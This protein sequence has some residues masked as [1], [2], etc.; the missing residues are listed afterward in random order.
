M[1]LTAS[2]SSNSVSIHDVEAPVTF[3]LAEQSQIIS[4]QN[5]G[6]R[7]GDWGEDP[8]NDV[9]QSLSAGARSLQ[10]GA[11]H[12]ADLIGG[13]IDTERKIIPSFEIKTTD[14]GARQPVG[15][16]PARTEAWIREAAQGRIGNQSVSAVDQAYAEDLRILLDQGYT[17]K[18]YIV[19]VAVPPQGQSARPTVTV[20][21]WPRPTP[22]PRP[23][24][25]P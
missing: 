19:E 8:A 25:A 4:G 10:N 2:N 11:R 1:S 13:K 18:P 23:N 7:L 12:G 17:I 15:D 24:T 14:S 9:V 3:V 5:A 6:V 20:T 16:L 22:M 21:P